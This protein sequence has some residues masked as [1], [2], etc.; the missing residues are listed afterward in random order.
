MADLYEYNVNTG[1][2]IP[3][4][5]EIK[6]KVQAEYQAALGSNLSLVDSTPQGVL[7]QNSTDLRVAVVEANANMV[8]GWNIYFAQGIQLDA[9]GTTFGV[10]RRAKQPTTVTAFIYGVGGTVIPEGSIAQTKDGYNF[11][12][13]T[14]ATIENTGNV[15]VIFR[16]EEEGAIP[17]PPNSLTVIVSNITGWERVNNPEQGITG[18]DVETDYSYR[19]RILKEYYKSEGYL[20]SYVARLS[21]DPDVK[22]SLVLEN[23][24]DVP[25]IKRGIPIAPNSIVAIVEGG[26]DED[27]R[28]AIFNAKSDGC[29]YSAIT[30]TYAY[31]Y[32]GFTENFT[33]GDTITINSTTITADT[34]FVIGD[35]LEESIDNIVS[36]VTIS[37]VRL[38]R[39]TSASQL[40][41][42]ATTLGDSGNSIDIAASKGV[43][44]ASTL[45]GGFSEDLS[46]TG[47]VVDGHYNATYTVV[48]NRPKKERF[49]VLATIKSNKYTGEN[50]KQEVEN[51]ILAWANNEVLSVEGLTLNNNVNAWEISS[52]ITELIPDCKVVSVY[53]GSATGVQASGS[54]EF[55]ANLALDDTITIGDTV[56]TAGV[57]FAIGDTLAQTLQYLSA[58]KVPN[59]DISINGESLLIKYKYSGVVGN[60][61][62]ISTT[63][64]DATVTS[65]SGGVDN[66]TPTLLN[67]D[68]GTAVVGQLFVAD[69]EV[70]VV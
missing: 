35:S 59:N 43:V 38:S 52:A 5:S 66:P 31:G 61:E 68:I 47:T 24:D 19:R 7:I 16:S 10:T 20:D 9:I 4:T 11:I 1:I 48:F 69:I 14:E 70:V 27:V 40:D 21:E 39:D 53:I 33:A 67:I 29:G 62:I 12:T 15:E 51:A 25:I 65:M 18:Y 8:N 37:G 44:S 42:T 55:A 60:S 32:I 28:Y 30:S 64:E 34:D 23:Y 6:S 50:L 49:A 45:I 58:V 22:D 3:Q 56:L 36:N 46:E 26:E 13:V 57:D 17:C 2:V 41:I 63:A 54:I